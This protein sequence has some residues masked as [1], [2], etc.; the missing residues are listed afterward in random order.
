MNMSRFTN[1]VHDGPDLDRQ[2]EIEA[3]KADHENDV[4]RETDPDTEFRGWPPM[5]DIKPLPQ[6]MSAEELK[7]KLK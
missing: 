6:I 1:P 2:A 3:E 4:A 7:E 5:P